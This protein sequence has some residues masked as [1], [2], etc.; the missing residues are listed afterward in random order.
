[1]LPFERVILACHCIEFGPESVDP[2][3][4]VPLDFLNPNELHLVVLHLIEHVLVHLL[5]PL[6]LLPIL[7][8]LIIR[9]FERQVQ[10]VLLRGEPVYKCLVGLQP[11]LLLIGFFLHGFERERLHLEVGERLRELELQLVG[12]PQLKLGL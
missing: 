12:L 3:V 8:P 4:P 6:A 9:L 5:Q 1:M 2:V 10:M 11:Q 7:N